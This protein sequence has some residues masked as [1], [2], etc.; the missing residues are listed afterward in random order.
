MMPVQHVSYVWGLPTDTPTNILTHCR[1][2]PAA[3]VHLSISPSYQLLLP[4]GLPPDPENM[5]DESMSLYTMQ[6]S[7]DDGMSSSVISKSQ[8]GDGDFVNAP[9]SMP[10]DSPSPLGKDAMGGKDGRGGNLAAVDAS[11]LSVAEMISMTSYIES[12]KSID[13]LFS[14]KTLKTPPQERNRIWKEEA[15]RKAAKE[16]QR[17]VRYMPC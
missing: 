16:A 13:N 11:N 14:R 15:A 2:T 12:Q 6:Q 7:M 1:L 9:L 5:D 3:H 10:L 17:E 4:Q 8:A